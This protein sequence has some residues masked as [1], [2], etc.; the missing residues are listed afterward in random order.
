VVINQ[1]SQLQ[2]LQRAAIK[3]EKD[4]HTN[5]IK[6]QATFNENEVA[7]Y[8]AKANY[9]I[10]QAK[11][12]AMLESLEASRKSAREATAAMQDKA[13]EV[14]FSRVTSKLN[15][16]WFSVQSSHYRRSHFLPKK[17]RE[18]EAKKVQITDSG[19]K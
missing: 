2:T 15:T 19:K 3:R 8:V 12:R 6:V 10:A 18:R 11:V 1:L 14:E 9:D 13:K 5:Y 17:Q 4:C 16:V 7:L